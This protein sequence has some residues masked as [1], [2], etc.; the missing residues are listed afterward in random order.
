MHPTSMILEEW[1]WRNDL[2]QR[3]Q[4]LSQ[5]GIH[6]RKASTEKVPVLKVSSNASVITQARIHAGTHAYRFTVDC[7][8]SYVISVYAKED[9]FFLEDEAKYFGEKFGL[10]CR[11]VEESFPQPSNGSWFI[12]FK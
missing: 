4:V 2:T 5:D 7:R 9:C 6:Y 12:L 1:A 11:D 10:V 3:Y 8:T